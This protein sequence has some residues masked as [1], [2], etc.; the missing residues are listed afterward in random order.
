MSMMVD[1]LDRYRRDRTFEIDQVAERQRERLLDV[2]GRQG[3]QATELAESASHIA[4]ATRDIAVQESRMAAVA[5]W[6]LP[7]IVE[8]LASAAERLGGVEEMLANP[9]E[10]ASSECYRGWNLRAGLRVVGGS[11]PQRP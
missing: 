10:T 8:H 11:S 5:D 7:A 9:R 1:V 3:T 4:A 2:L 6:A